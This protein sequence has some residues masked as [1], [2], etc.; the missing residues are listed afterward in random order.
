[1]TN[2]KPI[3]TAPKD[4]T[5]VDLWVVDEYIK[6]KQPKNGERICDAWWVEGQ[7]ISSKKTNYTGWVYY[8][9]NNTCAVEHGF[10][11]GARYATHWIP[12][13]DPPDENV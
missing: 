1:M 12:L 2:W 13:P 4:G 5:K 3:D 10:V 11:G 9:G 6:N 8:N 7:Y